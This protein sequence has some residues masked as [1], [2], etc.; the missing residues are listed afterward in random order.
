MI[1]ARPVRGRLAIALCLLPLGCGGAPSSGREGGAGEPADAP[2]A[3]R[4]TLPSELASWDRTQSVTVRDFGGH[5]LRIEASSL[6]QLR[7]QPRADGYAALRHQLYRALEYRQDGAIQDPGPA[8]GGIAEHQVRSLVD[9]H[10]RLLEGPELAGAPSSTQLAA[11][12]LLLARLIEPSYPAEPVAVGDTWSEPTALW[13][14]PPLHLA[15][16]EIDRSWTLLGVDGEGDAR[17]ARIGWEVRLRIQPFA[18][19]GVSVAGQG[20]L[21]GESVVSLADGVSGHA[22]L[23]L[24]AEVG[25]AGASDVLPLFR[26]EAKIRDERVPS[27]TPRRGDLVGSVPLIDPTD[28]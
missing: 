27:A 21:E 12:V 2:V 10:G 7:R 4:I 25:P 13:N 17:R 20:R 19:S 22:D 16:V 5:H 18:I 8:M 24:V 15:V 28:G 3:L 1:R 23:D 6:L 26:L 11:A 9:R 14:T